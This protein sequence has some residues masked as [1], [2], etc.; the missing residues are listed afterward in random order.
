M[1]QGNAELKAGSSRRAQVK[2]FIKSPLRLAFAAL[3]STSWSH[4]IFFVSSCRESSSLLTLPGHPICTFPSDPDILYMEV[5][6]RHSHK[7][8]ESEILQ[9][10]FS[11]LCLILHILLLKTDLV[12]LPAPYPLPLLFSFLLVCSVFDQIISSQPIAALSFI[13]SIPSPGWSKASDKNPGKASLLGG[14]SP[15]LVESSSGLQ[16]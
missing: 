12:F 8:P 13:A 10:N 9:N 14:I 16:H 7:T 4:P 5:C 11:F 1:N 3:L 15:G 6:C 2:A